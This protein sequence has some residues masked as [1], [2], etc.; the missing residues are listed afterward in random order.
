MAGKHTIQVSVLADTKKFSSAMADLSEATGLS[1]LGGIAK[2]AGLAVAAVGGAAA[3]GIGAAVGKAGDLE[4][5][6]GAVDAV[7]KDN[8][9]EIHEWA[10]SAANDLGLTQDEYNQLATIM[11]TQLR[12][13]GTAME[14][15]GSKTNDLMG[16]GSDLAAMFGGTTADAV[17]ALSSA[18][19]GE[20]DP[21]E[22]Y[23]V[24]LKQASIDAKAAEMGFEKVGGSLSDEAQQAATL[25]LI[26][27]QTTDAHGTFARE[28]D[29]LQGKQARLSANLGNLATRLGTLFLPL[30]STAV[31]LIGDHLM[32]AIEH[33]AG[34]LERNL[35]PAL[36]TA[37]EWLQNNLLPAIGQ[38]ADWVQANVVPALLA[39]G[40]YI[41]GT[42]MPALAGF[43][44]W[45]IDS[46][47]WLLPIAAAIGGIVAAW[48]LW[49]AGVTLWQNVT[50]IGT[51]IQAAFNAVL[52][53][54]PIGIVVT[55]I[56]GLVAA[57]VYL[58]NNNETVKNAIDKA[59]SVIK[60]AIDAVAGW[61]M[62][63]AVPWIT[64][65]WSTVS[66]GASDMWG[67][68]KGFFGSLRD[69]VTQ[70]VDKIKQFATD[71]GN[72]F[73]EFA[74][75]VGDKI[76]AVIQF[77]KDLPGKV[78]NAVSSLSGKLRDIGS[79]MIE[80]L[81]DGIKNMGKRVVD[82]AKGVVDNAIAGAKKLLG[83][84]SPSKVFRLIGEQTGDGLR[85]GLERTRRLVGDA[86]EDL[87][88]IV[89][90]Q[91]TPDALTV[92]GGTLAGGPVIHVHAQMLTPTAEA[93]RFIADEIRRHIGRGGSIQ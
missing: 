85:I 90:T 2:K 25:A 50:K 13:G 40:D 17:G 12:N 44:Q 69:G 5:S 33:W 46:Q 1:K 7:F 70:L 31:G 74:D 19:K 38:L 16:L 71:A 18:L 24:S 59:W 58:Y 54:N 37:G 67:K 36:Q 83:I 72:K 86:A 22:K 92:T 6:I 55:L 49:T 3:V 57:L 39:M 45:L 23:G 8:A 47:G 28:S 35:G 14:E 75:G 93:G 61:I 79:R 21:I 76:N 77:F 9:G 15:L 34:V 56:A 51:A 88:S 10:K 81:I 27:E 82:A 63:T 78:V 91:G 60:G 48:A 43:G 66:G 53:A 62:N 11:G 87:A 30:V 64:N 84:A 20:R 80:G 65:A 52:K 73:K 89:V 4:Q 32:P 26:M 29:T 42:L 68:I 41:T